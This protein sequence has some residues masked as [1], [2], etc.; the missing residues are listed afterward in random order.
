MLYANTYMDTRIRDAGPAL[1][2]LPSLTILPYLL[3]RWRIWHHHCGYMTIY[4]RHSLGLV[5]T[6]HGL[7]IPL[8]EEQHGDGKSYLSKLMSMVARLLN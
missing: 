8:E 1:F 7:I 5:A 3:L 6:H 4:G 2:H